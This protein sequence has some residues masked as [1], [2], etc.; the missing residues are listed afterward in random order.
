VSIITGTA[1]AVAGASATAAGVQ[2]QSAID[3]AAH[4]SLWG[5][6][7]LAIPLGVLVASL[8]GSAARAL[9]EGAHDDATIPR[10]VANVTVDGFI[11]GW[12]AVF[13]VTFPRTRE[14]FD[15]VAPAVIGAFGGLLCQYLRDNGSRW[16]EQ[17]WQ[18]A[19]SFLGKRKTE[20]G[21]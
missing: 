4:P 16:A 19:L 11:G 2:L 8:A 3:P 14:M 9:R 13:L 20:G 5:V 17:A 6:T 1:K 18:T 10:K 12:L 7:F 21:A 15:G